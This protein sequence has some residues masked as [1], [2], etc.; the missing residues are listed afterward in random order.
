MPQHLLCRVV[1]Q[2]ALPVGAVLRAIHEI[3]HVVHRHNVRAGKAKLR[4]PEQRW[5]MDQVALMAAEDFTKPQP[6]GHGVYTLVEADL[7]EVGRQ[8][9]HFTN[10]VALAN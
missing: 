6:P 8:V 9:A 3:E 2:S 4:H 1:M 7:V 10:A 5:Y